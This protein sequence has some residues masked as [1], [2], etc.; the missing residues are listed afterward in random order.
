VQPLRQEWN[1]SGYLW[2]VAQARAV[3][4]AQVAPAVSAPAVSSTEPLPPGYQAACLTCHDDHMMKP[5]R[6][7]RAQWD[8]E[9]TKMI[10]WGAEV[11]PE[12][13]NAILDYLSAHFK[14]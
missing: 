10:G 14:P 9:V 1:P 2:N 5:Q 6:L 3:T 7:T 13:R 12:H 11:K 8:R 4:V